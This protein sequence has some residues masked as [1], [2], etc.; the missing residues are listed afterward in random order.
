MRKFW[1]LLR[2]GRPYVPRMLLGLACV[3]TVALSNIIW[4]FVIRFVI[5]QVLTK[6]RATLSL[7]GLSLTLSSLQWLNVIFLFLLALYV[8]RGTI[9]FVRSYLMSWVGQRI[10]FD[11][12]NQV[13]QRLQDLPMRFYQTRGTGHI[14][15]RITG[16]V[17]MIGSVV[18]SSSIDMLT[19]IVTVSV[20]V[21]IL[22]RFNWQLA[23]MSF[24]A[25]PL[26]AINYRMFIHAI[27]RIW[28]SFRRKWSE[29]YGEL[30]ESIA[31]AQVVKAFARE[32]YE[33]RMFMKGMRESYTY[34][35]QLARLG[36]LLGSIAELI[37]MAGTAFILWYGGHLVL[38]TR[39][40]PEPQRFSPGTLLAFYSLLGQL[41]YPI[42]TLSSMNEVIQRAL[43]SADRVFDI[44][45]AKSTVEEAP[46][47]IPMPAMKGRVTFDHVSFFYDPEKLVL[48][49]IELDVPPGT[50]VALVGPSG[51][52]KTTLANLIPR[53][54]DPTQGSVEV[55]GIDLRKV[56]LRSLRNQIGLVLQESF[57]FSGTIKDNLRYGRMDASDEEIVQAAMMANAHEFIVK[58][59]PEGYD[60]E[61]GDRGVRLSGGQK[62]R[63]AIARA[64]LR[65][66]RILILDEATSSLDSEAEALIQEALERLMRNRTTFIIAHR[67]STVMAAHLIVVLDSGRLVESGSHDQL[68]AMD[69]LY[70]R[71]YKKQFKIEEETSEWLA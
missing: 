59:L 67:L 37:A 49:N 4:P 40:L 25:V 53:F 50:V 27:T 39:H 22:L 28:I 70:S 44:L 13:F 54:Y 9:A 21:V 32:K 58:E 33:T 30:H 51:S 20:T 71:L 68:V 48:E 36:T 23:L 41:Y 15:A 43:V 47:A 10:L 61:V 46:D 65:D 42:V 52:G 7:L 2:Y 38:A 56:T 31:G 5:D 57:L 8:I 24:L 34:S 63:I 17:D 19:N 18:S 16:D 55:D 66:P 14:M 26:F 62:Q 64:I 29:L 35:V 69:G 6:E 12:R 3:L 11:L 1:R 60:T 45:D